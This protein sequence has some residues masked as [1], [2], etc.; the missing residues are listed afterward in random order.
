MYWGGGENYE[1]IM[2]YNEQYKRDG[3][4]EDRE[5]VSSID[6][7]TGAESNERKGYDIIQT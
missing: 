1:H 7:N 3:S 6:T 2:I 5:T 4:V